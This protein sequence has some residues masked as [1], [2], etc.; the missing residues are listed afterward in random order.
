M[1]LRWLGWTGCALVLALP[2]TLCAQ[3]S[4]A[5][6]WAPSADEDGR[7][8]ARAAGEDDAA[9]GSSSD[10]FEEEN[11]DYFFLGAFYRHVIIPGFV[12]Q[13]FVDG[14]IDGSNPGVGITFNYRK[15]QFNVNVDLWWNNAEA[16]GYFRGL[17]DPR[18]DTEFVQVHMGV[19]FV[20]AEFLWSFPITDWFA[21]EL[22]FDLG[23]GF[24]YGGLTRTEAYESSDGA[25][26]WRPCERPGQDPNG[27]CE[28]DVAPDP[29]WANAGGH[30]RCTEPNWTS[31]DPA[32]GDTGQVPVIVPWVSLPHIALRFK[33][34]RQLQI[35]IDGGYGLYNFFVGGSVAYGF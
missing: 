12:Q 1:S 28:R 34:I 13:L 4:L 6:E 35:R 11:V 32:S 19:I 23:F 3:Q 16:S 25:G 17:G 14:G 7:G 8:G 26:D 22:G 5:E 20:T 33:P 31:R 30:Y 9:S 24:V 18:K 29:C 27:Y 21:F 10:P 15:N 2:G